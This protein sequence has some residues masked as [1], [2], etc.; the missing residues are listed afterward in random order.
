MNCQRTLVELVRAAR[1][2]IPLSATVLEKL[3]REPRKQV[4][5]CIGRLAKRK[6]VERTNPG[7]TLRN[8]TEPFYRATK[9]GVRFVDEGKRVTSG[10][11]GPHTG[12]RRGSQESFRARL[13]RALRIQKK[14][15]IPDL[16]EVARNARDA[17]NITSNALRYLQALES[18]GIVAKLPTREKGHAPS[19]PGFI[20]WAILRDLGPLAPAAG[21]KRLVDP[22]AVGDARF[23]PY[24]EAK[25]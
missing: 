2:D 4:L 11:T 6:L 5:E 3:T 17:E 22:N 7:R 12:V 18:A 15:T 23:I 9:A 14:A 1:K 20:R 19:S 13:W 8:Q 24:Q 10:P 16:I 21:A 25:R